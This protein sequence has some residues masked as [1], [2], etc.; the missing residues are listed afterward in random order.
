MAIYDD[1]RTALLLRYG[2]D[3]PVPKYADYY[4]EAIALRYIRQKN[5]M[6]YAQP[7]CQRPTD[8]TNVPTLVEF[9]RLAYENGLQ[10]R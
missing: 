3:L 6:M 1:L 4:D 9:F 2:K 8:N 5:N 10:P 7:Y